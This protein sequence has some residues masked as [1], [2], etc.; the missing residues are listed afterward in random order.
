MFHQ[1]VFFNYFN[2]SNGKLTKWQQTSNF[3]F[4]VNVPC[5][6]T[7]FLCVYSSDMTYYNLEISYILVLSYRGNPNCPIH[8]CYPI[9]N[10]SIKRENQFFL[11]TYYTTFADELTC[12]PTVWSNGISFFSDWCQLFTKLLVIYTVGYQHNQMKSFNIHQERY[13]GFNEVST[14][15][16][17]AIGV[18][19]LW[20]K[21]ATAMD[22]DRWWTPKTGNTTPV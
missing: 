15:R 5:I 1:I 9:K 8:F 14:L 13:F 22:K 20:I 2:I 4:I 19:V 18:H 7:M 6:L 12:E 21:L 16:V 17:R 11:N 10:E 3:F